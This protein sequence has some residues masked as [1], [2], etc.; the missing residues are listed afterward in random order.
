MPHVVARAAFFSFRP[1]QGVRRARR[2]AGLAAVLIATVACWLPALP[3]RAAE[4]AIVV[5]GADAPGDLGAAVLQAL[6]ERLQAAGSSARFEPLPAGQDGPLEVLKSLQAPTAGVLTV[7]T[8][9]SDVVVLAPGLGLSAVAAGE[10][11][12]LGAYLTYPFVIA[13]AASRPQ[14]TLDAL[15][16]ESA[17]G[18]LRLAHFGDAFLPTRAAIAIAR[19][20]GVEFGTREALP[21]VDCATLEESRADVVVTTLQSLMPCLDRATVLASLTDARLAL[22]PNAPTAAELLP[23]LDFTMWSALYVLRGTPAPIRERIVA[24]AREAVESE[25]LQRLAASRGTVLYW[26]PGAALEAR[27][28]AGRR[29]FEQANDVSGRKPAGG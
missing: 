26:Q 20:R 13:S 10:V 1:M 17:P 12:P 21:I 25:G 8:L 16:R 11:E 24:A 5:V 15:A 2:A 18:S 28:E 22:A 19:A 4:P 9:T 3:V 7:G 23:G 14:R 27:I 6:A 29:A